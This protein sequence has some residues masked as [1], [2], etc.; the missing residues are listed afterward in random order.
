M[1]RMPFA[2]RPRFSWKLR[3]RM[4]ALGE[5][6]LLMAIV[7]LTPDSFSGDG[8]L[9][10]KT[11]VRSPEA[12][13]ELGTA[14]ALSAL[15]AGADIVDLGAESTRPNATEVSAGEEQ[16]QLLPVVESLDEVAAGHGDLR[17][18]LSCCYRAGCGASGRGDC[19]RRLWPG[20]G[21]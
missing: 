6:T 14:A 5:R 17:G 15:N 7:N 1:A 4:L 18:H 13:A 19:E 9:R 12:I 20:V 10:R 3:T 16:E 8:L 2:R 11:D 21:Y